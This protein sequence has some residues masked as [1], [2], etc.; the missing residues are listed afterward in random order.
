VGGKVSL[1]QARAALDQR[2]AVVGED[3]LDLGLGIFER[4]IEQIF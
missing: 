1:H 4:Q 3:L 2:H